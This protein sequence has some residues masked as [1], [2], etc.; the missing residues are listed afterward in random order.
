VAPISA[1][2]S[3]GRVA[4]TV[5][6]CLDEHKAEDIVTIDLAG[7]SSLADLMIIASGRSDRHVGAIADHV[8]KELKELGLKHLHIEG[9]PHCDWVL[10]DAGD[11]IVHIF[12]PEVRAFYRLERLWTEE[13]PQARAN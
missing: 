12:R 1:A 6:S 8:F 11:V 4:D 9:V 10:V 3:S 7:K 5:R 13:A 2:P